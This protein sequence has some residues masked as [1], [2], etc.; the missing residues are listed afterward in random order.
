[1]AA[2]LETGRA[3]TGTLVRSVARAIVAA[4]LIGS[5]GAM[6]A[7]AD[8]LYRAQTVVTGQGEP[9]RIIG[10]GA[11]LEDVLIKVSGQPALAGD[12]RLGAY[13]SRAREFVSDFSYHDQYA[14]KPHH[15]EQGTR[16]RPYDLTVSFDEQKIDG[17]LATL[18]LKPWKAQRPVLGVFVEMQQ[19]P[20]DYIVTADGMQSDLQRDAL[21]A[22][23][24]KRGMRFVLPSAAA[25]AASSITAADL[26]KVPSAKLTPI[27]APQGGE[28]ALVG[29]LVWDD[30]D[31][32]W[33]TQW[34]IDW[35]GRSYT[36][37]MRGVTFDEAF[38]RGIG[39]AAQAL[40][41]NGNPGE[42][43]RSR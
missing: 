21:S 38:R 42:R 11:C 30:K 9:N 41:G 26:T 12:K 6:A 8:D 36:W 14:G 4:A 39:G 40:S 34:R 33:A 3:L 19:G 28:A 10:F 1:M 16:D 31:L 22:A 27:A 29:R 15:D 2:L 23:A 35:R 5:S 43:D 17:L 37:R 25:L 13:K 18:G 7:A 24:D 20:K 32:G